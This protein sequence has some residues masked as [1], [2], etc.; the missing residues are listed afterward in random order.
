ML[1]RFW[2]GQKL[3]L[4]L[5]REESGVSNWGFS[6]INTT[7]L[8]FLVKYLMSFSISGKLRCGVGVSFKPLLKIWICEGVKLTRDKFRT[9]GWIVSSFF[10]WLLLLL[11]HK[12]KNYLLRNCSHCLRFGSEHLAYLVQFLY[13]LCWSLLLV[14]LSS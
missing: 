10:G 13:S 11:G 1:F 5:A 7:S 14:S 8:S 2:G 9:L 12:G 4:L 3:D 6:K